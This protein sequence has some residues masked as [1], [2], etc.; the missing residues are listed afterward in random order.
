MDSI[1]E[2]IDNGD[3]TFDHHHPR[4][5]H[6]TPQITNMSEKIASPLI[7]TKR[8]NIRV[9]EPQYKHKRFGMAIKQLKINQYNIISGQG[10]VMDGIGGT[11][12]PK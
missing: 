1:G 4:L 2:I 10:N 5:I 9:Y 12:S 7:E 6:Q 3:S 8:S 11:Y